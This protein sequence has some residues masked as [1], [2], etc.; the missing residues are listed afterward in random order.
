MRQPWD[1]YEVVWTLKKILGQVDFW[2]S[3]KTATAV[4]YWSILCGICAENQLNSTSWDSPFIIFKVVF[5]LYNSLKWL[6]PI[7][8]HVCCF[9]K[10]WA[11][12][13]YLAG[14]LWRRENTGGVWHICGIWCLHKHTNRA[15][16]NCGKQIFY[17]A[18]DPKREREFQP[19][20]AEPAWK[21]NNYLSMSFHESQH[22]SSYIERSNWKS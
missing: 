18:F 21:T 14:S 3:V 13:R 9:F 20:T 15:Q 8:L 12:S 6:L 22:I 19:I 16:K 10:L 5:N 4:S 17:P 11:V 7:L 1:A 2:S